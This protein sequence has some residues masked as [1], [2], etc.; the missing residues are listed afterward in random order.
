MEK[1]KIS[2]DGKSFE[3]T[4]KDLCEDGYMPIFDILVQKTKNNKRVSWSDVKD[5]DIYVSEWGLM[6]ENE[7]IRPVSN[8]QYEIQ[9][10]ALIKE[11]V[12]TYEPEDD[13]P[14]LEKEEIQNVTYTKKDIVGLIIIALSGFGLYLRPVQELS[15]QILDPVLRVFSSLPIF[16][17][18]VLFAF[19]TSAISVYI[20]ENYSNKDIEHNTELLER[21]E[22]GSFLSVPSGLSESEE[23]LFITTQ[24]NIIKSK[25]KSIIWGLAIRLPA[26]IWL[27]SEI[28]IFESHPPMHLPMFGYISPARSFIGPI[29]FWLV[30][31]IIYSFVGSLIMS[32]FYTYY[33][34]KKQENMS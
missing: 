30:L 19:S 26:L 4:V 1:Y 5:E 6:I 23:S 11:Y 3:S 32:K 22:S 8:D 31:Y 20:R 9:Q 33:M 16:V 12:D 27:R 15:Y 17:T 14:S 7:I 21:F 10:R 13:S 24:K 28:I 25:I 29:G 34:D 2:M 18:I